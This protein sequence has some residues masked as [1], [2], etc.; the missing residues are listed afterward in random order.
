SRDQA[1]FPASPHQTVHTV[2]SH[3]AFRDRS[4][5]R[6]RRCR[7]PCDGSTKSVHSEPQVESPGV[8]LTPIPPRPARLLAEKER[9]PLVHIAVDLDELSASVTHS[10]VGAPAT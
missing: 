1:P 2:L 5:G 9:Q 10:K 6:Y 3:T 7:A 4:S 8:P